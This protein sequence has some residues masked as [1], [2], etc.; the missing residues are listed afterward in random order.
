MMRV[1]VGRQLELKKFPMKMVAMGLISL[2]LPAL[3]AVGATMDVQSDGSQMFM[4][5]VARER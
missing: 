4:V 5:S 3:I 1:V 2:V